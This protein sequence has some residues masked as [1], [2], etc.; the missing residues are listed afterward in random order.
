[1]QSNFRLLFAAKKKVKDPLPLRR[2]CDNNATFS[3]NNQNN[4]ESVSKR[5]APHN[6]LFTGP[7]HPRFIRLCTRSGPHRAPPISISTRLPAHALFVS[8]VMV[9]RGNE[10]GALTHDLSTQ[11]PNSEPPCFCGPTF[12]GSPH[13]GTHATPLRLWQPKNTALDPL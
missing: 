8:G 5:R 2:I 12:S 3:V 6:L 1:M 13:F 4:F 7:L 10:L 9:L 11:L